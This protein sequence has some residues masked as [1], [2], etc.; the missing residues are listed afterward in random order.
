MS[1]GHAKSLDPKRVAAATKSGKRFKT[2]I[3]DLDYDSKIDMKRLDYV[4]Y[5]W[6]KGAD[7]K[8]NYFQE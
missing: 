7:G 2:V 1:A 3:G 8:I 6:K 5:D 4:M